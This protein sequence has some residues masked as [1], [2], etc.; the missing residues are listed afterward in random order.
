[1]NFFEG[2]IGRKKTTFEDAWTE[3]YEEPADAQKGRRVRRKIR[4]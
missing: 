4:A 1:L 3:V 2:Q